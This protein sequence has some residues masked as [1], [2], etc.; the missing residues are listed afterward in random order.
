[1]SATLKSKAIG[2]VFWSF[3]ERVGQQGIS[4][5]I[6]I[7]LARLLLPEQFG[8]V[9]MLSLF[10]EIARAFV[11]SGFGAALIQRKKATDADVCSIFYF[12][13]L[14][15]L[16][17]MGL[18]CLLAPWA[19]DFYQQPILTPL[20]RVLSVTLVINSFAG[21]HTALLSKRIDFKTQLK[22]SVA[23]TLLS[24]VI[25]I[26]LAVRG[27]GVWSLA[28][29]Y[30]SNSLF[31]TTFLW[32]LNTW[33]PKLIFR[34]AALRE[35]FGFGSKL[36]AS[37]LINTMFENIY[38]VVIGR[39]FSASH[40]GLYVGAR[41]VQNMATANITGV[42]TQVAFPVFSTLQDDPV[43]L[44][45][46]MR[47]AMVM[48]A[49]VNF[50]IMAGLTLVARPVICLLMTE[51]WAAAVPWLQLLCLAGLLYPFQAL[52][53]NVLMA[54]GRSDL[55]FRLEVIK[56]IL[57]VM[58]IALTY[59]WG[60]TGMLWGQVA[61]SVL[62]Y[63]INSYYTTRL[64]GYRLGEQFADLAP[65]AAVSALMGGGVY[66]VHFVPFLGDALLLVAEIL[67]GM[68]LYVVLSGVLRLPAFLET[69]HAVR[70]KW[71]S[72]TLS[73]EKT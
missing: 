7:I 3:L 42:V 24:G 17:A 65:Y 73:W 47:K 34:F 11:D 14:V 68:A 40:L 39:L 69:V 72:Y 28:A 27:F 66:L 31:R 15:G 36:L 59:R 50:P 10:I 58:L 55:F 64:I 23:A 4:F 57:I 5:F 46:S 44:K 43:R 6:G 38:L 53:L 51:K 52:H 20:M 19:A 18:L 49:L 62:G 26:T 33:R 41:R 9:G 32:A 29:Q 48:L 54:R 37:G 60:V 71:R 2:G 63:Y 30:I 16:L 45:R 25:G 21:V 61:M 8:L 22:V 70:E 12:N 56:K 13:L 35:M 1:M 67:L